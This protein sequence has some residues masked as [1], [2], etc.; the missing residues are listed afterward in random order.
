MRR[1][2]LHPAA[3]LLPLVITLLVLAAPLIAQ[4]TIPYSSFTSGTVIDPDQVNS[5]FSTLGTQALNRTGGTLTGNVTANANVTVDGAD[6]SDYLDGSGNVTATGTLAVT[7][8]STLTGLV[9]APNSTISLRGVTYTL[10]AANASGALQNNGSGTLSWSAITNTLLDGSNHTD[11]SSSS[12]TRGAI[13]IGNSTPAWTALAAGSSGQHVRIN[14][15]GDVVFVYA[16]EDFQNAGFTASADKDFYAL[17]G[18]LTVTL[19]AC[20][21]GLSGKWFHFKND[22]SSSTQT[23]DPNGAETIDGAATFAMSTPYQ[24]ISIYCDGSQW[25]IF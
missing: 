22:N 9:T 10:P 18:T 21:A 24:A 11:T 15:A 1:L 3:K 20:N 14:S 19:P 16:V 23:I 8:A 12:A 25:F 17:S 13:I 2:L 4:I 7:G 5:N 6:I